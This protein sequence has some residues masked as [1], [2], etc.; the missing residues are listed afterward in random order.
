[1][2]QVNGNDPTR[3]YFWPLAGLLAV[4]FFFLSQYVQRHSPPPMTDGVK[5]QLCVGDLQRQVP[6]STDTATYQTETIV[7]KPPLGLGTS[8]IE[9]RV[10]RK[11]DRHLMLTASCTGVGRFHDDFRVYRL[12][13]KTPF[14]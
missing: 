12:E 9:L 8:F 11:A 2:A 1:M 4:L 7:E 10:W 6:A 5:Q 14:P 13:R 3:A